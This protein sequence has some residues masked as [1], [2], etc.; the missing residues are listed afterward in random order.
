MEVRAM[1]AQ[2]SNGRVGMTV[3]RIHRL[4]REG[5]EFHVVIL[6]EVGGRRTLPIWIGPG[7]A[8][9]IALQLERVEGLRPT[10]AAFA[11]NLLRAVAGKLREVRIERLSDR[12]YYA[13]AVVEAADGVHEVDARPSD[14]INVAL[15]TGSPI[16]VSEAILSLSEE[17]RAS[18]RARVAFDDVGGAAEI[19]AE[20]VLRARESCVLPP[21]LHQ[22]DEAARRSIE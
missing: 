20:A 8:T 5:H 14:A 19:T 2:R 22:D 4:R 13:V 3:A 10:T 17:A 15:I 6:S 21:E 7:E 12:V 1:T 18:E 16:E 9:S 11:A